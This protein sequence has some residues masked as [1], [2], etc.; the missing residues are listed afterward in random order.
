M[1]KLLKG[2]DHADSFVD[3][4]IAHTQGW[5]LH[6]G[7]LGET[8]ERISTAGLTV[9]PSKCQ[10]GFRNLNF[11]AHTVGPGMLRP[12]ESKVKAVQEA[13]RPQ[14]KR[15]VKSFLGLVGFFCKYIPNFASV[16]VPLT[17]LTKKG[18]PIK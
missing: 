13:S 6:V 5:T 16:A 14:T 8:F 18:L 17:D 12:G 15:R 4:L 2:D 9:K 1:Q 11:V 10:F 3:D 7:C